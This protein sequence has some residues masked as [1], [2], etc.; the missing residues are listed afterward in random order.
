MY[1]PP[2]EAG[3]VLVSIGYRVADNNAQAFVT[4]MRELRRIRKREGAYYWGLYRD[5]S[6]ADTYQEV[7]L[8]DSWAEHLRQHA[9]VSAEER[10]V[11]ER[12][13]ALTVGSDEPRVRHLIAVPNDL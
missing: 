1:A 7:Y 13:R 11:E 5:A 2:E 4:A 10:M 3:P 6:S 9:R 12:V 8:V